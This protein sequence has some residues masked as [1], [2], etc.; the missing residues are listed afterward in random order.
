M[1]VGRSSPT[2]SVT[3][4]DAPVTGTGRVSTRSRA[5]SL[6][7]SPWTVTVSGLTAMDPISNP[8]AGV[9]VTTG[10][11]GR[12]FVFLSVKTGTV[13][14]AVDGVRSTGLTALP[15]PSM[16]VS[17]N[18][19]SIS[20]AS[21]IWTSARAH[22][23]CATIDA[24]PDAVTSVGA[25]VVGPTS[26]PDGVGPWST[27]TGTCTVT[28]LSSWTVAKAGSKLRT[29]TRPSGEST[30]IRTLATSPVGGTSLRSTVAR[31]VLVA[32]G[33]LGAA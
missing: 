24:A 20:I 33:T 9:P 7:A 25:T 16:G 8:A 3:L 11:T 6:S 28:S 27:F 23:T 13:T 4:L 21:V 19:W 14:R 30:S 12:T 22:T 17:A 29:R 32:T 15:L 18:S 26:R 10:F 1:P 5:A 2:E 31:N